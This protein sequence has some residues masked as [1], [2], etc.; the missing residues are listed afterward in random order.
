MILLISN[1]KIK[2][3]NKRKENLEKIQRTDYCLPDGIVV[4][5]EQNGLG[6]QEVQTSSY[7]TSHGDEEY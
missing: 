2:E 5:R 6:N 4:R 3:T 7:K 1:L